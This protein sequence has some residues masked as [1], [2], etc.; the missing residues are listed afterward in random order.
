MPYHAQ[1]AQSAVP[2]IR[3]CVVLRARPLN[4]S[5]AAV[6]TTP[7]GAGY[8]R[9]TA[10]YRIKAGFVGNFLTAVRANVSHGC[11]T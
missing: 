3:W 6:S 11:G 2:C 7:R 5:P 1:S 4:L 9:K 8:V 10:I